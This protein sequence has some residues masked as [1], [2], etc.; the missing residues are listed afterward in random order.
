MLERPKQRRVA[1]A[2]R[3]AIERHHSDGCDQDAC[4]HK[5]ED[6]AHD[7]RGTEPGRRLD[8]TMTG[9]VLAAWGGWVCCLSLCEGG[10][11]GGG[12]T[13]TDSD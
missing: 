3:A 13:R 2:R 5:A 4:C 12:A 11:R 1:V 7:D 8:G 10:T 9:R 6:H